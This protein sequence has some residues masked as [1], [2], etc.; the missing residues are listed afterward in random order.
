MKD[1]AN[2]VWDFDGTL[3][4]T[5][6]VIVETFCQTLRHFG[7]ECAPDRTRVLL[8]DCVAAV[9]KQY[10][11][12]Y[13]IALPELKEVYQ[14]YWQKAMEEMVSV[15]FAGVKEVLEQVVATGRKNYIFTNRLAGE[16]MKYL[17]KHGYDKY[18]TDIVGKESPRFAMK[19][20][21]DALLYLMEKNGLDP[22]K[23]VVIGD[24]FCDLESGRRAGTRTVYFPCREVPEDLE[25][26]WRIESY[27]QMLPLLG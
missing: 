8:L 4:D 7:R 18:F 15:P 16:T 1:I 11:A 19:P 23:T 2:F 9:Q 17:Q 21:P 12:E 27:S 3:F 5:Y 22:D 20:A 10:A 25:C 6:P 24:R 26:D 13:R 14:I